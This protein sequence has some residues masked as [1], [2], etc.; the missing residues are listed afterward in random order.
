MTAQPI[1]L[2][3]AIVTDADGKVTGIVPTVEGEDEKVVIDRAA[4]K[5]STRGAVKR[6]D[7]EILAKRIRDAMEER[8]LTIRGVAQAAKISAESLYKYLRLPGV[9]PLAA[10]LR[11]CKAVGLQ[12]LTIMTAGTFYEK[13]GS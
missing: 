4:V 10:M 12:Q 7:G 2:H 6:S 1:S 5:A 13:G 3:F 9:A 11:I 8:R